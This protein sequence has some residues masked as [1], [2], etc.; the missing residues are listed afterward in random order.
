MA[1]ILKL[2]NINKTY[3]CLDKVIYALKNVTLEVGRGEIIAIMGSSGSGKSTL[4]HILGAI[5]KP[6]SG[7]IYLNNV[8]EKNYCQEPDATKIRRD[9]IGFIYQDYNLL[10]DFTVEENISLPLILA[11]YRDKARKKII[12]EKIDLVGLKGR[13]CHRPN[14]LS[15][16]QQQRVA[17]ARALVTNPKILLADEPTGNLDYNT[18]IDIMELIYK[19]SKEKS[20]TTIIVTHDALVSTYADRVIF[21]NDGEIKGEHVNCHNGK[22]LDKI[23]EQFRSLMN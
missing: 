11:N 21:F 10:D 12:N 20:Q 5:D 19:L 13:E 18:T 8:F 3:K 9:Y 4:L 17:I 23:L 6:D 22:D 2:E 1:G 15:G 16:G 14:E 7:K